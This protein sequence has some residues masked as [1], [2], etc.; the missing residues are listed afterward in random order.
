MTTET[1]TKEEDIKNHTNDTSNKTTTSKSSENKL[2]KP[3]K[4]RRGSKLVN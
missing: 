4:K 3:S 2:D 1:Q